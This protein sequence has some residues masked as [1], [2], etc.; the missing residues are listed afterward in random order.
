[1]YSRKGFTLTE[2]I[3]A[4]V[5]TGLVVLAVTSVDITS[6]KFFNIA[7]ER[8]RVQD[9]IKIAMEHIV[10]HLRLGVGYVDN[11]G[12]V[13]SG[14][15]SQI[16]LRLDVDKDGRFTASP[17]DSIIQY[18]YQGSP[19]YKIVYNDG[20]GSEDLA[21]AVI[22]SINFSS[23]AGS[24]NKVDVTIEALPDPSESEG[25]DNPKITLTSSIVLRAM[26]CN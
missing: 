21:A 1:M 19:D 9:E 3:I 6:R 15:G 4:I 20:A 10:T 13:V 2:I 8:S 17:P 5:L 7:S 22:E 24:P 11:P 18:S 16:Q 14:G 12:F 26:S 23:D 25:P